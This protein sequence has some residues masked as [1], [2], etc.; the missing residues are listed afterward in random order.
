MMLLGVIVIIVVSL[1]FFSNV[2]LLEFSVSTSFLQVSLPYI[3]VEKRSGKV[4]TVNIHTRH[5][6]LQFVS[7]QPSNAT[8]SFDVAHV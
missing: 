1:C 2:L 3:R 5:Q 7:D 6:L 4:Y 8:S